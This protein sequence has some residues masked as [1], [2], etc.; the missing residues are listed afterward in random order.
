MSLKLIGV[1]GG[2]FDPIHYGHIK[3]AKAWQ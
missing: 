3:L 1:L 2:A